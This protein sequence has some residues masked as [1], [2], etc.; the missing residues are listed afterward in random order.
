MVCWRAWATGTMQQGH[1]T[2]F[3]KHAQQ[4]GECNFCVPPF[5]FFLLIALGA[6]ET[7]YGWGGRKCFSTQARACQGGQWFRCSDEMITVASAVEVLSS[8]AY[9]KSPALWMS[10]AVLPDECIHIFTPCACTLFVCL[11]RYMLFYIKHR[12]EYAAP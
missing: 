2:C 5:S 10:G 11:P 6:G 3:V 8:E 7:A 12:L 1:Y 4:V 9:V